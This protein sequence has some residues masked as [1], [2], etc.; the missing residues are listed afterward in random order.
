MK[1][2]YKRLLYGVGVLVFLLA[3]LFAFAYWNGDIILNRINQEISKEINGE[4]HINDFDFTI[5]HRFPRFQ[6]TLKNVYL[7]GTRYEMY[8]RDFF[9]ARRIFIDMPLSALWSKEVQIESFSI[10]DASII[11]FR[12]KDGYSNLEMFQKKKDTTLK[13]TNDQTLVSFRD[14][15]LR[16]VKFV[17]TDSIKEKNFGFEF[18][19][20]K[21]KIILTDSTLTTEI[22]GA[23]HFNELTFNSVNGSFL[24]DKT[25]DVDLNAELNRREKKLTIGSSTLKASNSKINLSG[26]F[27]F[28]KKDFAL[29]F[30]C[31]D[32]K[33]TDGIALLDNHLQKTLS[34]F[35]VDKNIKA[36]VLLKGKT[37]PN[38]KP[39][40]D[41]IFSST[42]TNA[43]L[44]KMVLS[45]LDF[46][47]AFTNHIDSTKVFNDANS[48]VTISN[49]NG[50]INQFPFK[51]KVKVT[52]LHDP[53]IDLEA[54]CD[55]KLKSLNALLDTTRFKFS[56]GT[57][58]T[59]LAYQ[60]KLSEYMDSLRT[61]YEGTLKGK[62]QIKD[63]SFQ[64]T[65]KKITFNKIES[66]LEFDK[67]K[68]L[69]QNLSLLFGNSQVQVQGAL[70]NFVPF[71][72]QPKDKGKIALTISSPNLDLT[73]LVSK[74]T[75]TLTARQQKLQKKKISSLVDAI[76]NKLEFDLT[77]KTDR[78]VFRKF[79][80][81]SFSGRLKLT[82]QSLEAY[83][84]AM[85]IAGGTMYANFKINNFSQ[86][87]K[88]FSARV[89]INNT[90][91]NDLFTNFDNFSQS[92]IQNK[93]L[94]GTISANV[95]FSAK[96][97]D[98]FSVQGPSMRGDFSCKVKNG[99]LI[100]FEPMQNMSNFLFKNRDFNNIRFAEINSHFLLKGSDVDID[101]MEIESSV[102]S[103]FVKGKFSFANNTNLSVQLPLSN[104]RKRD[105]NYK[106]KNVGLDAKVGPSI[107]LHIYNDKDG[108][109]A[110]A[111]DP[112]KKWA[113]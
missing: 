108:S 57:I 24:H 71:F 83:P 23:I 39:A 67:E 9:V 6:L 13:K 63:G 42:K 84:I 25:T 19:K 17:Y 20:T 18:L 96:M 54:E 27:D 1:K 34:K 103:F 31:N 79:K 109:T 68:F 61:H 99:R 44:G 51:G 22:K 95:T 10:E 35:Q 62:T 69:V 89:K 111:Y 53:F 90:R 36:D 12:T 77:L 56:N 113:K 2:I 104:L 86:A 64:I 72:I 50:I 7:R 58:I 85:N 70:L 74:N 30:I 48:S 52:Q 82:H 32:I 110:I 33:A 40:V 94:E 11:I 106:P 107:F 105:K 16:K 8:H 15:S 38:N 101:K 75:K 26:N 88:P 78:L 14:I 92:T 59:Q 76:Y 45:S 102:L 60:G 3:S 29:H 100:N 47:G 55:L 93:N 80:A 41:I 73:P 65:D 21:H 98:D 5:F 46:S 49:V 43:V 66:Q 81:T 97:N 37:L 112:F 87:V 28:H 4:V 91:I